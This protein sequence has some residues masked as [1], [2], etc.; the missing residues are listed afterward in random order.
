[1]PRASFSER[2]LVL[3][4]LAL[5]GCLPSSCRRE[6]SRA[7]TP[8]DSVSRQVA[9]GVPEDTLEVVWTHTA[10][11]IDSL[12]YPRTVLYGPDGHLYVSDAQ[13]GQVHVFEADG[14]PAETIRA[15]FNAP[16][17]AG[18]LGDTLVVFNPAPGRFDLIAGGQVARS[19]TLPNLPDDRTLLRYAAVWGEGFAFKG[20]SDDTAPFLLRFNRHGERVDSLALPGPFWRHAG[21]LRPDGDALMS[22]NFYQP[23]VYRFTD[24]DAGIRL[25]TLRFVGF[26]SPTLAR[27]RLFL[28]GEVHEPP[29]LIPAAA[30]ADTL[31]FVLNMRPGWVQIDAFGQVGGRL[32]ARLVQPRPGPQRDFFPIH[33]DARATDGGYDLAVVFTRPEGRVT[34]YRWTP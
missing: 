26:D 12:A 13:H 34:L 24:G 30:P 7:L 27:S 2:A 25:D 10:R 17:L 8:A 1:M 18:F 21:L 31:L 22:V 32:V 23:F 4:L 6:Q 14:T 15:D 29:L 20:A 19:V 9:L 16:Y 11:E 33:L 28:H 5:C 3:L